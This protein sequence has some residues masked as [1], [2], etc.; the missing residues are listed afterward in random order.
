ML[1][2]LKNFVVLIADSVCEAREAYL[3]HKRNRW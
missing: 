2:K 1:L 3:K